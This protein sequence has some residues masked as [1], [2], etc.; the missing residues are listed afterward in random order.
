MYYAS[1]VNSWS[2]DS[3]V[4]WNK[5]FTLWFFY[6]HTTS[7]AWTKKHLKYCK[8][9]F[10]EYQ[11][12]FLCQFF[13]CLWSL[14]Y[15]YKHCTVSSFPQKSS[16]SVKYCDHGCVTPCARTNVNSSI[17]VCMCTV[18]S[19]FVI[20]DSCHYCVCKELDLM[21]KIHLLVVI[22]LGTAHAH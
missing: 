6:R 22:A 13:E 10:S 16:Q 8:Y 19:I 4:L 12:L 5:L 17:S 21:L 18:C 1:N 9:L 11:P 20:V 3:A 2:T 14:N 7:L 15:L